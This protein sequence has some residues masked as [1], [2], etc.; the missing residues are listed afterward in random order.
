MPHFSITSGSLRT[1]CYVASTLGMKTINAA[2]KAMRGGESSELH[3]LAEV[4]GAFFPSLTLTERGEFLEALKQMAG[5]NERH[6]AEEARL[7]I[8]SSQLRALKSFD[9]EIGDHTY[10]HVHCRILSHS[11]FAQEIEANKTEL[12]AISGTKVRS[13]SLPYGLSKDL[14]EELRTSLGRSGYEAVFLSESV[15]NEQGA[16]WSCLDRVNPETGSDSTLFFDLEVLPR[17]RGI[18]NRLFRTPRRRVTLE[19][20]QTLS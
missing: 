14:T 16:E 10:S 2:A 15:A 12:E 17:L 7:Y 11:E 19:H 3:S 6:L 18:R 9:F 20:A 8:S 13:F 4:F 5:I 1:L